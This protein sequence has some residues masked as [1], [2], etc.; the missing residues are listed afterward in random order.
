MTINFL[1]LP[2]VLKKRGRS[3]SAHYL[4]IHNGL[5]TKPVSTGARSVAWP[6]HEIEAINAARMAGASELEIRF[7]VNKLESKRKD[8]TSIVQV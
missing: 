7:L 6:E 4:D 5:C 3:K 1:R 2:A 8:F